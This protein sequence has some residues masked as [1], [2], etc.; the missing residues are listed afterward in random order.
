M[1]NY[2]PGDYLHESWNNVSVVWVPDH[3]SL[4]AFNSNSDGDSGSGSDSGLLTMSSTYFDV[5]TSSYISSGTT[6][7]LSNAS[8]L[9]GSNFDW[10]FGASRFPKD[11][12]WA[13]CHH[14][15]GELRNLRVYNGVG[16]EL[17]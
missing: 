12:G 9:G 7:W 13:P 6:H 2:V 5:R 3:R 14:F 11:G 1:K 4:A 15:F 8:N 16:C 17:N 10:V